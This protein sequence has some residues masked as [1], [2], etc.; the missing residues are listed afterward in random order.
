M[1]LIYSRCCWSLS[2]CVGCNYNLQRSPIELCGVNLHSLL[3]AILSCLVTLLVGWNIYT[4]VDYKEI[5]SK[6]E[7]ELNYAHNKMDCN[8]ADT[9][10]F[11]CQQCLVSLSD[12]NKQLTKLRMIVFGLNAI[13]I[14]SEI[15]SCSNEVDTICSSLILGL[16]E[17]SDIC[18]SEDDIDELL[19]LCGSIPK[20]KQIPASA[21]IL[22]L[23]KEIKL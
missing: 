19:L 6:L 12:V 7:R 16:K 4:V 22:R 1:P 11:L 20:F 18:F 9:Y 17:T 21:E 14:Y 3:I 15:P 2:I 23:I 8:K 10:S 5:R 13:K